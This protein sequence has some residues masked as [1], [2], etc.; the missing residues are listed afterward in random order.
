[1]KMTIYREGDQWFVEQ[2]KRLDT[3][4]VEVTTVP[5][6]PWQAIIIRQK[7]RAEVRGS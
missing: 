6:T 7:C 4:T 5:I 1:M 2:R 3:K